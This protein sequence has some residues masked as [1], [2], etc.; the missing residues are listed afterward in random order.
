MA[1]VVLMAAALAVGQVAWAGGTVAIINEG[2]PTPFLGEIWCTFLEDNGYVCTVFPTTGPDGPLAEFDVVI[3]MSDE[4]TDPTGMLADHM[5]AHKGVI[6]WGWAPS[7]LGIDADPTVQ[8]WIGANGSSS[9]G[10]F[11]L[12]TAV[13]PILGD[14]PLGSYLEDCADSFCRG[15]S[16]T[17]GHPNAK[18][19]A[20]WDRG[21]G[22]IG[23]MRNTWEGGQSV[24]FTD[25]FGPP[26]ALHEEILLNAMRELTNP[27]P[28]V[29]EWGMLILA[30]LVVTC[31]SIVLPRRGT[32]E[33]T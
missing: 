21:V 3:D 17:A 16:D 23:L 15:V 32:Q 18:I 5:R 14:L 30:L 6:V 29:S 7:A 12:T 28:A 10:D 11:L 9:G 25:P 13:D 33:L 8:A 26:A 27:V 20:R 4:W 24:Y 31:G 2:G 1:R 22:P 19:L